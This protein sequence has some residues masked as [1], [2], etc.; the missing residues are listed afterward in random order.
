[1]SLIFQL[2]LVISSFVYATNVPTYSPL[3]PPSLPLAVRTPYTNAWSITSNGE[4]LN[5]RGAVFWPFPSPAL[6][7]EGIVTVDGTSYQWLGTA[8]KKLP[9]MEIFKEAEPLTVSYDSQYSNFTFMAG[10]AKIVARFLSPVIPQDLCRTSIPLS[11]LTVSV[12]SLSGSS[13]NVSLYGNVNGNWLSNQDR[14]GASAVN[15]EEAFPCCFD[16]YTS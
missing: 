10:P 15:C 3:R 14:G 6:G 12:E 2:G 8:M 9:A 11:Y 16:I 5:S 4:T 13:H 1:M 7:W